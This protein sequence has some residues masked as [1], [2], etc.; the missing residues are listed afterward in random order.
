MEMSKKRFRFDG[1]A[2][3]DGYHFLND[4]EGKTYCIKCDNFPQ[5][6]LDLLNAEDKKLKCL[7]KQNEWL[8]E[9]IS[10]LVTYLSDLGYDVG[11]Q[12]KDGNVIDLTGRGE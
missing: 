9:R 3:S 2:H 5:E 11:L 7:E 6:M 1:F 4:D 8:L 10:E 12:D